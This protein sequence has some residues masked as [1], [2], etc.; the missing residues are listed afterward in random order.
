MF[1][2]VWVKFD[3]IVKRSSFHFEN[4]ARNLSSIIHKTFGRCKPCSETVYASYDNKMSAT[5]EYQ[6]LEWFSMSFIFYTT[7]RCQESLIVERLNQL[8]GKE[9]NL[10][11]GTEYMAMTISATTREEYDN[12][13]LIDDGDMQVISSKCPISLGGFLTDFHSLSRCPSV[14][15]N[16]SDYTALMRSTEQMSKKRLINALF[17]QGNG[18]TNMGNGTSN[19]GNGT[20][21]MDNGTTNMVIGTT[22]MDDFKVQACWETYLSVLPKKN[23][24][25]SISP[26]QLVLFVVVMGSIKFVA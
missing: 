9:I 14:R 3:T 21:N 7:E 1:T 23:H 17:K 5:N 24:G 16:Y 22:N 10:P 6:P 4:V 8:L 20:T 2:P 15:L 12:Y 19:T 13:L 25:C 18:T 26:M 11:I